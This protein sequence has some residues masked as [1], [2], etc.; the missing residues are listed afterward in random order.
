MYKGGVKEKDGDIKGAGLK[1]IPFDDR[2]TDVIA[3]N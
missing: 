2:L 1:L 3:T